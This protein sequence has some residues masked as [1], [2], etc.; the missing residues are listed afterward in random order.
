MATTSVFGAEVSPISV[1]V[2]L[3]TYLINKLGWPKSVV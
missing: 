3:Y 1:V 2:Y